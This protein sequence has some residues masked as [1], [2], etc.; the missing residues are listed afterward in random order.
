MR[1]KGA[2]HNPVATW[3]S[4]RNENS[5]APNPEIHYSAAFF[6]YISEND[7]TTGTAVL[8]RENPD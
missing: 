4:N 6:V 3:F 8:C 5:K 7:F 1:K 2:F